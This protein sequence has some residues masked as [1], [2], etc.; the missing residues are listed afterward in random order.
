MYYLQFI[1]HYYFI[2]LPSAR[3]CERVTLLSLLISV[4]QLVILSHNSGSL[5]T[6][7]SCRLKDASKCCTGQFKPHECAIILCFSEKSHFIII[8]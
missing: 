7:A 4:S 3:M 8:I 2:N 1:K 6:V 5:K